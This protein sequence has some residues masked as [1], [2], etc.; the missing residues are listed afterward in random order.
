MDTQLLVRIED[1]WKSIDLYDE[2]PISVVIQQTDITD[3]SKV[4]SPFS[5]TFEVPATA[6]NS[7]VFNNYF[8]VNGTDF[9]PLVKLETVVQ[10]RG[11]IIF[12]GFLRMNGVINNP[13]FTNYELYILGQV[14]DFISE[15]QGST[16][17]DLE[18]ADLTHELNYTAITTSWEAKDNDTDGLFGGKI[19]YPLVHYGYEYQDTASGASP[20]FSYSFTGDSGFYLS[21]RS[22]PSTVFKPSIR[23]KEIVDRIFDYAGYKL[24]SEFLNTDYFKSIYMDT[25][26]NGKLGVETAS[27]TNNTNLFKVYSNPNNQFA[28]TGGLDIFPINWNNFR[29]DGYDYL[30]NFTE[31]PPNQTLIDSEDCYFQVP[32]GGQYSFNVRFN[33][34]NQ[35]PFLSCRV[36][37]IANKGNDPTTLENA[38]TFAS[39]GP[40]NLSSSGPTD[41]VDWYFTGNC[42]SGE[43]IQVFMLLD[44]S[45]SAG[46]LP[47]IIPFDNFGVT[48]EAPM[49]ELYEGPQYASETLV[50]IKTGLPDLSLIDFIRTLV[51]MFNLVIITND[52][53]RTITLEPYNWYFNDSD[54]GKKDWTQT[55]DLDSTYRVDPLSFDLPK[56]QIWTYA[57]P[58]LE[59]LGKRFRDANG[60]VF[61]RTR[62]TT[63]DNVILK[64]ENIYQV[65]FR[66]FPTE[67]VPG[68]PNFIIPK[69]YQLQTNQEVPFSNKNHLFFW[70]GNRY[71]YKDVD[72]T[73]PG[74]WY[75]S[76][77]ATPVQQTTYPCVN[78]LSNL[79]LDIP[80]LIS[81]LNFDSQPDLFTTNNK[82]IV[83]NTPYTLYNTF[84][85]TFNDNIYSPETK[86][87]TGRFFFR[88]IDIVENKLTDKIFIK[89]SF[90][91]I[92]KVNEADLLNDKLT[93]VSLIKERGGYYKVE[94]PAP[95]YTLSGNT[96]YPGF[97]PAFSRQSYT[98]TVQSDVCN[99]TSPQTVLFSF[100]PGTFITGQKVYYDTGTQLKLVPIGTFIK[101]ASAPGFNT[102]VVAD[103]QGRIIQIN[104]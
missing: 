95:V 26:Q 92:E 4:K 68:A 54:R 44:P 30:N 20:S 67:D 29:T 64:G 2:L 50:D 82:T 79:D 34:F 86:R 21:G 28:A 5:K 9:N 84:W 33:I 55:L 99:S 96:A 12:D 7:K 77:G 27:G 100:G 104:C 85:K 62:F 36:L 35:L 70:T 8:D 90:Y 74:Y 1:E 11:T 13:S 51:Q 38:P 69:V 14:S 97:Q 46:A 17:K 40:F 89:D 25:F 87:L 53:E 103:N 71:A 65:P 80:S 57:D 98:G 37:F 78:H 19:L 47:T 56:D 76:S 91:Q 48:T 24:N 63:P 6:N 81:D 18:W 15:I 83:Y 59:F 72:K 101:D 73:Q 31:G 3:F 49:F 52:D 75:L 16:L 22:V 39:F 32:Y 61:G 43:Y 45:T 93:E 94:P 41:P 102:F 23:L 88:P 58:E 60:Y 42:G 66:N 10:Y